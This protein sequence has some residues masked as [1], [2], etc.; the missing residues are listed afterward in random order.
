MKT[1]H[2]LPVTVMLLLTSLIAVAQNAASKKYSIQNIPFGKK[3]PPPD[4]ITYPDK[5]SSQMFRQSPG[6]TSLREI[7]I[8][9]TKAAKANPEYF[10][11]LLLDKRERLTS[12]P[13][14]TKSAVSKIEN[15]DSTTPDFPLLKDINPLAESNPRNF[16]NHAIDIYDNPHNDSASYAVLNDVIYFVANDG[17]H[18]KI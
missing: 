9:Q 7:D 13:V 12:F 14:E 2:L 17:I 1:Q 5:Y 3:L 6:A 16:T 4:L 18:G 10:R 11:Q 15:T 8:A